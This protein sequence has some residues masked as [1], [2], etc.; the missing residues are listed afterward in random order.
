MTEEQAQDRPEQVEAR[1]T[2]H[3]GHAMVSG[4]ADDIARVLRSLGADGCA[5]A[6]APL[7]PPPPAEATEAAKPE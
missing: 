4:T 5:M 6:N 3:G 1:V 2:I 7:P